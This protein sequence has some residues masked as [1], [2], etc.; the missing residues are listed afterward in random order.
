MDNITFAS[1]QKSAQL[2]IISTIIRIKR[3]YL[4]AALDN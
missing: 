2:T 3:V 1:I 4:Y